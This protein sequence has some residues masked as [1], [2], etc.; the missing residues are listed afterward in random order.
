MKILSIGDRVEEG[1]YLPHSRFRR[2]ANFARGESLAAVV[3]EEA[4]RGPVNIVVRGIDPGAADLLE[5]GGEAIRVGGNSFSRAEVEIYDSRWAPDPIE[6]KLVGRNLEVLE[7][8]LR[9]HAPGESLVFLLDPARRGY[10]ET[11]FRGRLAERFAAAAEDLFRSE[12]DLVEGCRRL[13]GLGPGLTPSGDDFIAG[14]LAALGVMERADGTDRS[15][16]KGKIAA[17]ARSANLL[18]GNFIALAAAGRFFERLKNLLDGL[19]G[20]EPEA[21][22]RRAGELLAFGASSGSDLAVGLVLTL[23]RFP[24]AEKSRDIACPGV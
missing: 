11:S 2:S 3:G 16:L 13:K 8:C 24:S 5:I 10:P 20:G 1:S 4:G 14:V 17:A 21:L 12:R 18:S 6:R 19:V 15:E 23:K 22:R 9:R 7:G